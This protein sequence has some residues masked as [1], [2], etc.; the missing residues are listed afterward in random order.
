MPGTPATRTS[1]GVRTRPRPRPV[2]PSRAP[3][4]ARPASRWARRGAAGDPSSRSP[5]RTARCSRCVS[6]S[7][8]VPSS[9]ASRA[10]GRRTAPGRPWSGRRGPAP[11]SGRGGRVRRTG[12]PRWRRRRSPE[13][14]RS[15]RS[16]SPRRAS[17][18]AVAP[19]LDGAPAQPVGPASPALLGQSSAVAEQVEGPGGRGQ[20]E[21]RLA[22]GQPGGARA[23]HL[24][25]DVQVEPDAPAQ[26]VRRRPGLDEAVA[27]TLRSR[28]AKVA[29]LA[30]GSRGG[31]SGQ[32]ASTRRSAGIGAPRAPA[33]A[34]TN[35]L[36]LR[37]PSRGPVSTTPSRVTVRS[38]HRA[39]RTVT[40]EYPARRGPPW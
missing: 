6:G 4:C 31:R 5:R 30:C 13:P 18:T 3:R 22:T 15:D 17:M 26:G 23:E 33:S 35:T 16:R 36:A 32:T 27:D 11:R 10:N 29:R 20:G 14:A 39:S 19:Q 24:V 25:G 1:E 7:G 2:Q 12:R 40:L 38:P 34:A 9:S 21:G 37:V 28:L 8:S